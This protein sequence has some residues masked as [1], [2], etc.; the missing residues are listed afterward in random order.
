MY[1]DHSLCI[2]QLRLKRIE[3]GFVEVYHLFHSVY[4]L[5]HLGLDL[6]I[7]FTRLL[8]VSA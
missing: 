4:L 1:K 6:G 7:V 8:E 5:V 3:V 2:H